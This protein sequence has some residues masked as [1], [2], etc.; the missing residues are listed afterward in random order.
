VLAL[1]QWIIER[2]NHAD[3]VGFVVDFIVGMKQQ[4]LFVLSAGRTCLV[5]E[6]WTLCLLI[7]WTG[8]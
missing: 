1:F 7:T 5:F 6:D 2:S 4:V 3:F 8:S